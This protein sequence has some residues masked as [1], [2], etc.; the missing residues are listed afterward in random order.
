MWT[1]QWNTSF[2]SA[3]ALQ[4]ELH[5]VWGGDGLMFSINREGLV[6]TVSEQDSITIRVPAQ[7]PGSPGQWV[8]WSE[9]PGRLHEAVSQVTDPDV[10]FDVEEAPYRSGDNISVGIF[11]LQ[12]PGR[13]A[14]S[15]LGR[16]LRIAWVSGLLTSSRLHVLVHTP[17]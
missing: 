15:L 3:E 7:P 17:R 13:H 1:L 8:P 6:D 14:W 11:L 16:A 12:G 5:Q 4:E 9:L 10:T 2:Q